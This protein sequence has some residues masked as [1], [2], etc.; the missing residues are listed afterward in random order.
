MTTTRLL[1]TLL[2]VLLSA[3]AVCAN[4]QS[5]YAEDGPVVELTDENFA[6]LVM[7]NG[8]DVW[9]VAHHPVDCRLS[10]EVEKHLGVSTAGL[11][12]EDQGL[13]AKPVTD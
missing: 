6:D 11:K 9:V 3:F 12:G 4:A 1:A 13:E 5:P 2:L 10:S 7:E 8:R